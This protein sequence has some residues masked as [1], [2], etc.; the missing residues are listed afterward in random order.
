MSEE[1][2]IKLND[3]TFMPYIGLG[4]SKSTDDE[5]FNAVRFAID[6]GY[7]L[8]DCSIFYHNEEAVGRAVR[9]KIDDNSVTRMDLFITGKLWRS[10]NRLLIF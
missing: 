9:S 3:G 5:V 1:K 4:T 2:S 6:Q 8:L 10:F 7:R